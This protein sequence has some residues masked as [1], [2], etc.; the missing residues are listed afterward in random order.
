DVDG[1]IGYQALGIIPIRRAGDGTLPEPGWTSATGW[2]GF[3]PFGEL[4]NVLNPATGYIVTA[5]NAAAPES[6]PLMITKDWDQGYRAQEI[7]TR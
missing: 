3:I 4:P 6:S 5:N 2:S 7:T 1:N